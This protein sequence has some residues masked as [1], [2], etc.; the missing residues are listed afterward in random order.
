MSR[1]ILAFITAL[2]LAGCA[3]APKPTP[4]TAPV[5]VAC[6]PLGNVTPEQQKAAAA[7]LDGLPP[8]LRAALDPIIT[9]WIALRDADRACLKGAP[10]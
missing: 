5:K 4:V 9:D 2:V 3:T 8:A 1:T 6:L 7:T 10:S